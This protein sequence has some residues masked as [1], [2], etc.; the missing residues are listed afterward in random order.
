MDIKLFCTRKDQEE[1]YQN[2]LMHKGFLGSVCT[3]AE[4][5][6]NFVTG[7]RIIY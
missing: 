3:A 2:G 4:L 5:L 7:G 6:T 1:K